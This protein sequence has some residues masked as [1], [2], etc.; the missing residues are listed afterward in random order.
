MK[1][2]QVKSEQIKSKLFCSQ[3]ILISWN[4]GLKIG[5]K[6]TSVFYKLCL[7]FKQELRNGPFVGLVD[8]TQHFSNVEV[9]QA[10]WRANF[11]G[12]VGFLFGTTFWMTLIL[13]LVQIELRTLRIKKWKFLKHECF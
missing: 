11:T 6:A 12:H 2:S 5:I 1:R 8:C 13:T 7:K 4:L 9:W 10:V 3:N